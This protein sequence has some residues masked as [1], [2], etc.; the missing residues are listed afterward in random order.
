M[1]KWSTGL[2]I[3]TES[4]LIMVYFRK[5]PIRGLISYADV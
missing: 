4:D 1:K 3:V 5:Y 2:K